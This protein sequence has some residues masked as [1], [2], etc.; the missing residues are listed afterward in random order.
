MINKIASLFY[1]DKT[2]KEIEK[3]INLLGSST[4]YTA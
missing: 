4:K 2:L 1:R 3:K